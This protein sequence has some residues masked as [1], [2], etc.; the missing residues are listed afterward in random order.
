ME[1]DHQGRVFRDT[2]ERSDLEG[3][4]KMEQNKGGVILKVAI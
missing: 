4:E 1:W 3:R 2:L